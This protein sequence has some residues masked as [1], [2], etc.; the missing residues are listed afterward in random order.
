MI[1]FWL[2]SES[3]DSRLPVKDFSAKV[4]ELRE[5]NREHRVDR[6]RAEGDHW[7]ETGYQHIHASP[8]HIVP[9]VR[10]SH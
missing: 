6:M 7:L 1:S 9:P 8:Q 4:N 10:N 3:H 2:L 5:I